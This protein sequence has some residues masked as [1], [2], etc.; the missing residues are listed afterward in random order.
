MGY[1]FFTLLGTGQFEGNDSSG[2][3]VKYLKARYDFGNNVIIED[4][5]LLNAVLRSHKWD[6]EKIVIVGTITSCWD[7]LIDEQDRVGDCLDFWFELYTNCSCKTELNKKGISKEQSKRLETYLSNLYQIPVVLFAHEDQVDERTI[8]DISHLYYSLYMER[9][10]KTKVLLDITHGFRS[11][12]TLLFQTFQLHSSELKN[13]DF[14]L[15]YAEFHKGKISPIRNLTKYWEISEL[16]RQLYSFQTS[17]RGEKLAVT[18]EP[19]WKEG[20]ECIRL[21]SYVVRMDYVMQINKLVGKIKGACDRFKPIG[22]P[23]WV[24]NLKDELFSMVKRLN[25]T[26]PYDKYV[27]F[28]KL[29]YEK[30]LLTQAVIALTAALE[31]R[32]LYDCYGSE[33]ETHVGSYDDWM[34]FGWNHLNCC[35]E[36]KA[37][38]K[39]KVSVL[40]D[41]RNAIAHAAQEKWNEMP[42][43]ES[44]DY[45]KLQDT[46]LEVFAVFDRVKRL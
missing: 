1:T 33:P 7:A 14:E 6:I 35:L 42:K 21:L 44:I 8:A 22:K 41:V 4:K 28:S 46:V 23:D 15:F 9:Y 11:M 17:L 43:C 30:G 12:G 16:N 38:L 34:N 24:I 29:L 25:K 31:T 32:V 27:A 18:L 36:G 20:A 13:G 3:D 40:R 26:M 10:A 39:K 37:E 19:F 2:A 45:L 5:I